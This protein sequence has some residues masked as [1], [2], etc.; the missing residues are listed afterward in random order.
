MPNK[1]SSRRFQGG[2]GRS[3]S[4]R[5]EVPGLQRAKRSRCQKSDRAVLF[6]L[7][8]RSESAEPGSTR[9]KSSLRIEGH[10]IVSMCSITN[11]VPR[12]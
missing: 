10:H 5:F 2:K 6:T 3:G 4:D 12:A 11:S 8:P 9:I 1:S 7:R